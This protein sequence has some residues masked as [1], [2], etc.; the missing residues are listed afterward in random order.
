M[1][2]PVRRWLA[3]AAE[4]HGA[5]TAV[6]HGDDRATYAELWRDALELAH[7]LLP[8]LDD[9]RRRPI[10]IASPKSIAAVTAILAVQLTGRI[11]VPIDVNSP[12]ERQALMRRRLGEP[13]WLEPAA[14]GG[15]LLDGALLPLDDDVAALD[16]GAL[17]G[18]LV[19]W[20]PQPQPGDPLYILFTSGTTGIPRGVTIHHAAAINYIEWAVATFEIDCDEVIGNQ[21]PMFFDHFIFD[22]FVTL[23]TGCVLHLI[24]ERCF[25]F[26]GELAAYLL[27]RRITLTFF[28]PAV[29]R[30]LEAFDLLD[31]EDDLPRKMLFAGEAMP[32]K[33][34]RWLRRRRPRALLANLYGPAEATVDVTC[35]I[36][37]DELA[38]LTETPIGKPC[39]DARI[40][41]VDDDRNL[42]TGAG[43]VGEIAIGGPG[44]GLGYWNDMQATRRVFV[45]NPEHDAYRETFY[46]TGDLGYRSEA[47]GLLYLVGRKDRQFKHLGQRIEAGEIEHA[48]LEIPGTER[49]IIRYDDDRRRIVAFIARSEP[50]GAVAWRRRL[51]DRLPPYMIPGVTMEWTD[52]PKLPNGKTDHGRLWKAYQD[53]HQ[54]ETRLGADAEK[55]VAQ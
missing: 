49:C 51:G 42:L 47:D 18:L 24:P 32:L 5:R 27:E 15:F 46:L 50:L 14:D 52:F 26:P 11:F 29:Y 48:V 37:G 8:H 38:T 21:S 53:A 44:V 19:E 22:L 2:S 31:V 17:A 6:V 13:H 43:K 55:G 45:Q 25:R 16:D 33:T 28:V 34:I 30:A 36:F 39:A 1:T 12:P 35:W 40:L 23:A 7:A 10:A 4:R 54:G 41:L 20:A 9:D 3:P